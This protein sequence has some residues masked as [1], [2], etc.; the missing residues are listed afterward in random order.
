MVW[1][2]AQGTKGTYAAVLPLYERAC[3]TAALA[4]WSLLVAALETFAAYLKASRACASPS[5]YFWAVIQESRQQ[6]L[7]RLWSRAGC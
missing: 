7:A 6:A 1:R 2:S 3:V 4:A 5:V